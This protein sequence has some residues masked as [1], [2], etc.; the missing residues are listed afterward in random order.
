MTTTPQCLALWGLQSTSWLLGVTLSSDTP[1][2]SCSG[3]A[4]I[5]E[6]AQGFGATW[7]NVGPP[8]G[9]V[10]DIGKETPT[11]RRDVNN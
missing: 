9:A 10:V 5:M 1:T 11:R 7:P 6:H 4:T 2:E 8:K 3:G